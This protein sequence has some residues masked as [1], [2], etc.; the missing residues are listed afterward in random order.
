VEAVVTDPM[1]QAKVGYIHLRT[2]VATAEPLLRTA[3]SDFKAQG[4]TGVV[5]DVRYDG[6][7]LLSTAE[8]LASLLHVAPAGNPADLMY[9]FTFNAQQSGQDT[10]VYFHGEAAA[11]PAVQRVAFITTDGT[12]SASELVPNVLAPYF[13]DASGTPGLAVVGARSYGKPVGQEPFQLGSECTDTL[14]LISFRL[15]NAK[16]FGGYYSGL[17]ADGFDGGSCAAADDLAHEQGDPLEASTQ[18]ALQWVTAGTCPNGAIAPASTPGALTAA[19]PPLRRLVP[20]DPSPAQR[21]I[22]GLF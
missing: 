18:A 12:A 22:P 2:F 20:P 4:V 16:G 19:P 10:P 14:Y 5:I 9:R 6:G 17:P 11:L 13:K 21:D 7:G 1:S 3:F 8:V 15:D